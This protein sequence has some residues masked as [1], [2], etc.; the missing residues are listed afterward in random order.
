MYEQHRSHPSPDV[1]IPESSLYLKSLDKIKNECWYNHQKDGKNKIGDY[2]KEMAK[3]G[4]QRQLKITPLTKL[5]NKIAQLGGWKN[6][7][8]IKLYSV[9]L[10]KHKNLY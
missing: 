6:V 5:P 7:Q 10:L 3:L 2:M 1:L 8:S 4:S 9:Y